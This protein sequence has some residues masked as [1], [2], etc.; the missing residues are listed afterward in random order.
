MLLKNGETKMMQANLDEKH[1][2]F[3]MK[4]PINH[5]YF[6]TIQSLGGNRQFVAQGEQ[7]TRV[8]ALGDA[9]KSHQ[10]KTGL[11]KP[12]SWGKGKSNE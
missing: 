8:D 7:A 1:R 10:N 2:L 5:G 3:I 6:W 12:L 9:L 4:H 11:I